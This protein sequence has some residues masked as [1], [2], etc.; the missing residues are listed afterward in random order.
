M[1]QFCRWET[2]YWAFDHTCQ[3]GFTSK[4]EPE[5][6]KTG[7]KEKTEDMKW[8]TVDGKKN[9]VNRRMTVIIVSNGRKPEPCDTGYTW[10]VSASSAHLQWPFFLTHTGDCAF[11]SKLFP[12]NFV[13]FAH[14]LPITSQ[15][16]TEN[17]G[18]SN[19]TWVTTVFTCAVLV[20]KH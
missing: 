4:R 1:L 14:F 15:L 20:L 13:K 12:D 3:I 19:T 5:K 7:E 6:E 16:W 10:Q 8:E 18:T 11:V 9:R 2:R 17:V